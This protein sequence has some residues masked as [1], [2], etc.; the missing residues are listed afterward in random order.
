MWLVAGVWLVG[1]L[2]L[3]LT[4][5]RVLRRMGRHYP[6]SEDTARREHDPSG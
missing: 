3:A 6:A 2:A 1:T 4:L 5:G